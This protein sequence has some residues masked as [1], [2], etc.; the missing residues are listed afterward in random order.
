MYQMMK[1]RYASKLED[2]SF[3]K[4]NV[5]CFF[6]G[7]HATVVLTRE[8]E[9]SHQKKLAK[10]KKVIDFY[11]YKS[12]RKPC[13]A[14]LRGNKVIIYDIDANAVGKQKAAKVL[15]FWEFCRD[16]EMADRSEVRVI[17]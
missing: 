9:I 12:T 15:S 11:D 16:Y 14:I 4:N 8:A 1:H 17:C 6:S 2:R 7:H 5:E 13:I 3:Y 10:G